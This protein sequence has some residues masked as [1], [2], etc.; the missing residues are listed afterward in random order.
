MTYA[1]QAKNCLADID[2]KLAKVD[3]WFKDAPID[4]LEAVEQAIG[5]NAPRQDIAEALRLSRK[6]QN[7]LED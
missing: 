1:D 2:E 3:Q 7:N 6:I 5:Q 4:E